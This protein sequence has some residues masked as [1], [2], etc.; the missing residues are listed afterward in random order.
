MPDEP[1]P[2]ERKARTFGDLLRE[3]VRHHQPIADI[4]SRQA[5]LFAAMP[6]PV[7]P[8]ALSSS[9]ATLQGILNKPIRPAEAPPAASTVQTADVPAHDCAALLDRLVQPQERAMLERLLGLVFPL[10]KEAAAA[11]VQQMAGFSG[12]AF[13]RVWRVY[14]K[15][16]KHSHRPP[17]GPRRQ[18]RVIVALR[19]KG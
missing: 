10:T 19:A 15:D 9:V 2:G 7:I 11:E 12:R 1:P 4:A 14:P 18:R 13:A 16:R 6:R 17:G 8:P 3:M 5:A